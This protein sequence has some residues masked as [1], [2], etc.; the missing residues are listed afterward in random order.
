MTVAQEA[1]ARLDGRI[2]YWCNRTENLIEFSDAP[3][4]YYCKD[5][6][7][8]LHNSK[9]DVSIERMKQIQRDKYR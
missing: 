7:T 3:G 5:C 4:L 2:C 9:V 6:K 1:K 8:D